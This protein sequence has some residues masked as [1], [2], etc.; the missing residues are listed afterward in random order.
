MSVV[1]VTK[2]CYL[3]AKHVHWVTMD[4]YEYEYIKRKRTPTAWKVQICYV[5]EDGGLNIG[6]NGRIHNDET[7]VVQIVCTDV[8]VCHILQTEIVKQIRD[9][10][11]DQIYLDKLVTDFLVG[12][13]LDE[14]DYSPA[15]VS[16]PRTPKRT[17]KKVP[18]RTKKVN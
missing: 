14:I 16:R 12:G 9:Q 11:P 5:P 4:E 1:I 2:K 17:S 7:R 10:L 15:E 8:N 6:N 13:P 18:R 3:V